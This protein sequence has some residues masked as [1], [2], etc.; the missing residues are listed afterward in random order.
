MDDAP[1]VNQ[2]YGS[3]LEVLL[4]HKP[5]SSDSYIRAIETAFRQTFMI[6]HACGNHRQSI[7][8]YQQFI[9][10]YIKSTDKSSSN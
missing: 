2:A 8:T 3:Y 6:H 9:E 7:E 10:L 4:R 1:I 5:L